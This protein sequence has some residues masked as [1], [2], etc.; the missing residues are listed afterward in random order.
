MMQNEMEGRKSR[1]R[2]A[3]GDLGAPMQ[4]RSPSMLSRSEQGGRYTVRND[5]VALLIEVEEGIE[6]R[7]SLRRSK[8]R[9]GNMVPRM[10]YRRTN[11][12]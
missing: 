2:S 11:P 8:D 5:I 10:K 12:D 6:Q 3:D 1:P 4:Q 7:P 9:N